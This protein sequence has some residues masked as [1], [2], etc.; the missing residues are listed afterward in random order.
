MAPVG[1]VSWMGCVFPMWELM[2]WDEKPVGYPLWR[3]CLRGSKRRNLFP[4]SI[5]Q[6][7]E[8]GPDLGGFTGPYIYTHKYIY[9][10]LEG[11]PSRLL[12]CS[13]LP[14]LSYCCPFWSRPRIALRDKKKS[15]Y[16]FVASF[17]FRHGQEVE[18]PCS[19]QPMALLFRDR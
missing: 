1:C 14:S 18:S 8:L 15:A 10:Y 11:A 5:L 4:N 7:G 13:R 16:L 3:A 6:C 2:R 17:L 12:A 9:I 19:P